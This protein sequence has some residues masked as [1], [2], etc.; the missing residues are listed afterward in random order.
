MPIDFG[1][2]WE[3]KALYWMGAWRRLERN[4]T[5]ICKRLIEL[6]KEVREEN[7]RSEVEEEVLGCA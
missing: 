2:T 7:N 1:T 3:E 5:E 6:E 4:Y